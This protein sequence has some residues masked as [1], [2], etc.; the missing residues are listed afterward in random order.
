MW[1]A[2]S[3][4]VGVLRAQADGGGWVLT[5]PKPWSS[6]TEV[7]SHA[8]V[9]A[10]A[11]SGQRLF[12][13]DLTDPGVRTRDHEWRGVGM[14]GSAAATVD[15]VGVSA[16]PVGAPGAYLERPGFWHGAV[17]VAAVWFGGAVAVSHPLRRAGRNGRLDAHGSAHLGAVDAALAA[18]RAVLLEAGHLID[19]PATR[20]EPVITA[21]RRA[22]QVRAVVET[23]VDTVIRATGRATG[24]GPLAH[25]AAHA[26]RVADLQV[27]VRQSHAEADLAALGELALDDE[28]IL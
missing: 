2:E 24:P 19:A 13:V 9:T 10:H 4:T 6:G 17:A 22:L 23:A 15:F 18:A 26:Q 3:A 25:D 7:C 5:G 21:R 14:T 12:V 1:A 16:V 11:S 28:T 8:L 20:D 27:Y